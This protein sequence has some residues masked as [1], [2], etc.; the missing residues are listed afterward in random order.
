MKNYTDLNIILDRSGSMSSIANDITGGIKTFLEKEKNSGDETKVS[1]YQFDDQ[2]ETVFTD[3]DIKDDINISI[4]PRGSTALLDAIGKTMAIVGEKLEKMA[5]E[6]RPNRVL[7]LVITDGFENASKEFSAS[8]VSEKIKHQR[9]KY[10]W[11]FVFLGAGEDAVLKQHQSLG[12]M[13]SSSMGFTRDSASIMEGF[14]SVCDSYTSYKTL[15]RS[16]AATYCRSF[17]FDE[18]ENDKDVVCELP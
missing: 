12:I 5:E 9:E 7:F 18:K 16:N 8:T 3:K 10:A 15:D 17:S 2:Y 11:D 14:K 13:G 4:S 1:F 6:D